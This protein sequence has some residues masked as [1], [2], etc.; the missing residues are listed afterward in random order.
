MQFVPLNKPAPPPPSNVPWF[1]S[2]TPLIWSVPPLSWYWSPAPIRDVSGRVQAA[3][4]LERGRGGGIVADVLGQAEI[5]GSA[6]AVRSAAAG[7]FGEREPAGGV[8]SARLVERSRAVIAQVL[9]AVE[10]WPVPLKLYV[11]LLPEL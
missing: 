5:A 8:G 4:L 1:V 2:P 11:P 7:V 3:A 6:Q 9:S 10:S